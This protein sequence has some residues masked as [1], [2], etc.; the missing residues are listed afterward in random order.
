[1]NHLTSPGDVALAVII[2]AITAYTGG[3]LF[4]RVFWDNRS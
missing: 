3:I 2:I 1:M 4:K